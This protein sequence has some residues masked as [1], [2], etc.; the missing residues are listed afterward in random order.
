MPVAPVRYRVAMPEPVSHEFHVTME[1]PALPDR[2]SLD[3]VFPAWA[4]GSYLVRDFVRHVYELAITDGHRRAVPAERLGKQ[5]PR[6]R[7][8]AGAHGRPRPHRP[9]RAAGQA[10]LAR[11]QRRAPVAGVVP[12]VRLRAERA[13]LV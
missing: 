3:L 10:A 2:Q 9:G 6:L 7:L 11:A 8:R 1:I 4:P 5:R 12:G 13:H